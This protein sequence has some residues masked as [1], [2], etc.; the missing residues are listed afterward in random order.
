MNAAAAIFGRVRRQDGQVVPIVAVCLVV[1]IGFVA[2]V[3]DIGRVYVAQQQLDAAVD[4][5]ALAGGQNLPNATNAYNA[6]VAYSGAAGDKN[7]LSGTGV[8]AGS[9]TVTFECVS[10]AP[11]Y[12]SGSCPT[13]TS[14]TNCQPGGAQSPQ[15]SGV[16]TCNAVHVTETAQ[17]QTTLGSLF[18][19]QGF[20]VSASTTAAAR[21]GQVHPLNV[22][23]ILDN[24][25]S[26][27][28]GCS[29]TVPG[30]SSPEKIDC[31]KA[32][33][34]ALLQA[35]WPCNSS[36]ASCGAA[37]ANSGGQLGANVAAP[38]DE[39]GLLV[40]PAITG[41]PP[42]ATTVNKEVDCNSGSTFADTYP[43]YVPYTYPS[44][45]PLADQYLGYQAVALSSDFRP[46]VAS[47][48]LNSTTSNLVEAVDWGQCG[49]GTYPGGNYYGLKDIGGQ[50]SYLAGAI[51]EAQYLLTQNARPGTT[52]AIIVE[53]DG[54]MNNPKTFTDDNPCNSAIDAATQAKA[55][56]TT[57]YAIAYGSNGTRCP[58]TGYS[59]TDLQTMQDIASN[60]ETFYDQPASG[61]LTQAFQQVATDLTDSRLIP[62]C[63]A[64][65][66]NC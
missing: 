11:N 63:T 45:I 17:V 21:G 13:D 55:A 23:V 2:I 43:T 9:P 28:Q 32:G 39:V 22:E 14:N 12:A 40:F 49:G 36:L 65:P 38:V 60:S 8:T 1:L 30:I 54:Q 10:H 57:I 53:S 18:F 35:L 37:T 34:R 33:M 62:D 59:Y 5:A 56:G 52:N 47:T 20:T 19:P 64:A 16:T 27:T 26:M 41:N 6:A 4:S 50:G 42:S 7:A 44:A 24:T 66:P 31:A 3:L 48:T 58:D 25:Q 29:A 51:T 61:D 46:S 15:P